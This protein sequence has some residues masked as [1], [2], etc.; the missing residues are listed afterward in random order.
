MILGIDA[1]NISSGGGVTHLVELLSEANPSKHGFKKV[2]I[3]GNFKV[4][5]RIEDRDWLQKKY[6]PMLNKSLFHRIFWHKFIEAR[7]A[8]KNNCDIVFLPGGVASSGFSPVV[9]MCRNMLPFEWKELKRFGWS[10]MS[11]KLIILHFTQLRS[12]KKTTGLIF[13]T[14]YAKDLICA[15]KGININYIKTIPHGV[16]S[17]FFQTD[18]PNKNKVFT[19]DD[20][21]KILYVSNISP[22]KHQWN[23]IEAVSHLRNKQIP[24]TL[25]LVGPSGP[26]FLRMKSIM[27]KLDPGNDFVRYHGEVPHNLLKQYYADADIGVFASSCENMPNILLEGMASGLPMA[28]SDMGPMPEI[29]GDSDLY[30]D[31]LNPMDIAQVLQ[32][33]FDSSELRDK[34]AKKSIILAKKYTWGLCADETFSFLKLTAKADSN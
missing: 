6:V 26:S 34:S 2:I 32:K 21:C 9:T 12:F 8:K 31:P 30:F 7:I 33:M 5:E 17:N 22:Y 10:L 29:M 25:D 4:L 13:L 16:N 27:D 20:P 23:V 18:F 28:C 1:F 11:L 19:K 14:R 24:I 15:N 3:W